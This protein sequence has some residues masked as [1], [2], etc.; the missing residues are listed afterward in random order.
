MSIINKS[1]FI[2][3]NFYTMK[4][5]LLLLFAFTSLAVVSCEKD[6]DHDD[7]DG[8]DHSAIII[9]DSENLA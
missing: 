3:L 5:Y 6:D 1:K 4:K 2:N 9:D 8:H 7:H